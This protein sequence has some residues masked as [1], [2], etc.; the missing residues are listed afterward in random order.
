MG[1]VFVIKIV[2][3]QSGEG[4]EVG[5][6]SEWFGDDY[7]K[8]KMKVGMREGGGCIKGCKRLTRTV[9]GSVAGSSSVM[10]RGKG[11]VANREAVVA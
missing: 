4:V 3:F 6:T 5:K 1:R 11:D 7:G 9:G 2:R 10:G 8:E